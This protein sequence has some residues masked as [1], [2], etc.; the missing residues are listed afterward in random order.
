MTVLT[1]PLQF[2]TFRSGLAAKGYHS[3]VDQTTRKHP[4]YIYAVRTHNGVKVEIKVSK[5]LSG[6]VA[7]F[8]LD[9]EELEALEREL[10][11]Q[12][13]RVLKV[14]RTFLWIEFHSNLLEG[15]YQLIAA[16]ENIDSIMRTRAG[17][18]HRIPVNNDYHIAVAKLIALARD[19]G[20]P[21]WLGRGNGTFDAVDQF[22]SKGYSLAGK[23]QEATGK[24]AYREHAVP[25]T[26]IEEE[27]LNM[28]DAGADMNMVAEMIKN[29]LFIVRISD[30]EQQLLDYTLGLQKRMPAGWKFGD[31]PFARLAF[32][33]IE[34]E[35]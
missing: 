24:P 15:L 12:N 22:I 29:N 7:G 21:E 2:D 18:R 23:A 13:F 10:I 5:N 25:C 32:A 19:C 9:T 28:Y 34:F 33:G 3:T 1:M 14:T 35:E 17:I 26:V 8:G 20:R 16:V 6:Y 27:A 30:E 4:S 31:S 11:A